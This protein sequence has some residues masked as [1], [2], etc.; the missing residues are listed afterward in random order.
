MRTATIS[1]YVTGLFLLFGMLAAGCGDDSKDSGRDAG[2]VATIGETQISKQ[3]VATRIRELA[4]QGLPGQGVTQKHYRR[5]VRNVAAAELIDAEWVEQ[6][7]ADLGVP[8]DAGPAAAVS[9]S[10]PCESG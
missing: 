8:S 3:E 7:A 2:P 5:Y 1:T 9:A 10:T 6:E 4:R